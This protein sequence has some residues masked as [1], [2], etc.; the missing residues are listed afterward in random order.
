MTKTLCCFAFLLTAGVIL[1]LS[2]ATQEHA[3]N[4]GCPAPSVSK[5]GQC[6]L[7]GD[8]VLTDT[9]H[10]PSSTKLNCKGHRLVPAAAGVLDDPRTIQNEFQPSQPELAIMVRQ[11]FDTKIQNC[12]IEGFDFGILLAETKSQG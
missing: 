9:L 10:L 3:D 4:P 7:E 5:G 1:P 6:V 11:A 12:R 8:A 2:G